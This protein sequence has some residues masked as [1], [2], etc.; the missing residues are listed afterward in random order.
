MLVETITGGHDEWSDFVTDAD[1]DEF[2]DG[3]FGDPWDE[4]GDPLQ[5]GTWLEHSVWGRGVIEAATGI[6]M[7]RFADDGILTAGYEY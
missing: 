2:D 5:P 6:E 1:F 4:P 7:E 3:D